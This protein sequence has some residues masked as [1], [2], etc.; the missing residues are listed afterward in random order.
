MVVRG[1]G[2]TAPPI[3]GI[4]V[5]VMSNGHVDRHFPFRHA[6]HSRWSR[7]HKHEAKF[8]PT[9]KK[10]GL[11]LDRRRHGSVLLPRHS[12]LTH[13]AAAVL[14]V[15]CNNFDFMTLSLLGCSNFLRLKCGN[16]ATLAT[17]EKQRTAAKT[18]SYGETKA[19]L[20]G[21]LN[22]YLQ[23]QNPIIWTWNNWLRRIFHQRRR[24]YE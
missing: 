9:T 2:K 3:L 19:T 5:K 16:A 15:W 10:S 20:C 4:S 8:P 17:W 11:Q 7:N 1:Q 22:G 13:S 21:Y 6:I 23:P 14:H 12:A 24:V 18:F